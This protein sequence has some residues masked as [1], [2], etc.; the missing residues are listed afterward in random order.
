MGKFHESIS[1]DH[2]SFIEKQHLFFVSTSPRSDQG[3]INLSPKGLDCFKVLD[4]NHVAYMDLISS[5]NETAAHLLE[6]GNK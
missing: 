3:H 5:G 2:Q 1:A 6:N 4:A